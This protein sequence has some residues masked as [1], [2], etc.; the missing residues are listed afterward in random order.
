MFDKLE[1]FEERFK[2]VSEK[3]SDPEI[4][5]GQEARRKYCKE[6]SDLTPIVG[7]YRE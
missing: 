4:I 1:A 7:K 3:I 5:N 2:L 6:H